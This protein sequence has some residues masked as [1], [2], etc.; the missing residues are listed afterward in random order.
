[1]KA[2]ASYHIVP[3][4]REGGDRGHICQRRSPRLLLSHPAPVPALPRRLGQVCFPASGPTKEKEEVLVP[5]VGTKTAHGRKPRSEH[6]DL[7]ICQIFKQSLNF[8]AG[9]YLGADLQ[10]ILRDSA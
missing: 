4:F 1:M 5:S 10:D 6:K 8:A 7:P 2:W 9:T 3:L